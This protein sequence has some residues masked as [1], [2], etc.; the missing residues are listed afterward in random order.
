MLE[1]DSYH[2]A[3]HQSTQFHMADRS[4]ARRSGAWSSGRQNPLFQQA[5]IRMSYRILGSGLQRTPDNDL[6]TENWI[7]TSLLKVTRNNDAAWTETVDDAQIFLFAGFAR[8]FYQHLGNR[9]FSFFASNL[10][11]PLDATILVRSLP[12]KSSNGLV[13][14]V[15]DTSVTHANLVQYV[16]DT[17]CKTQNGSAH[18]RVFVTYNIFTHRAINRQE[19]SCEYISLIPFL[20]LGPLV[21]FSSCLMM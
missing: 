12:M 16:T 13:R 11:P 21:V 17:D 14:D 15:L 1:S 6:R 20:S 5:G 9:L 18:G 4:K 2:R 10:T 19:N 7:I 8:L 3:F